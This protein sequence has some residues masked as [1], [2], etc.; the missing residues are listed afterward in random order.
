MVVLPSIPYNRKVPPQAGREEQLKVTVFF[1][2]GS[3]ERIFKI[4]Q[5]TLFFDDAAGL[6]RVTYHTV[7]IDNRAVQISRAPA[8]ARTCFCTESLIF[9]K[10]YCKIKGFFSAL[11][12]GVAVLLSSNKAFVGVLRPRCRD[13]PSGCSCRAVQPHTVLAQNQ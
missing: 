4:D 10:P 9:E 3:V 6:L 13:Q 12:A 8:A 7:H 5:R 2:L 1:C 11:L